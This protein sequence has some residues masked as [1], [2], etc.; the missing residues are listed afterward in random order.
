MK[1]DAENL[2][3][4]EAHKPIKYS[5]VPFPQFTERRITSKTDDIQGLQRV[6][7]EITVEL[8]Q[9]RMSLEEVLNLSPTS[10]GV[11]LND[12]NMTEAERRQ[13]IVR[14]NKQIGESVDLFINGRIFAKGEIISTGVGNQYA[15]RVIS[16]LTEAERI[17]EQSA[18]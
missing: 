17:E 10:D 1:S 3:L 18:R 7:T 12:P 16:I 6:K 11:A 8:A 15:V 13:Y 5:R 4:P 2:S 14:L 9:A